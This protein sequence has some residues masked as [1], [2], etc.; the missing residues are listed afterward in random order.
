METSTFTAEEISEL[1][2]K[3]ADM[4]LAEKRRALI[5]YAEELVR[6]SKHL[7]KSVQEGNASDIANWITSIAQNS[8]NYVRIAG[9]WQSQSE[10]SHRISEYF[11]DR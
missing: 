2:C 3:F 9:Q 8:S 4:L 11:G 7:E 6:Y 1:V 5:A 10:A